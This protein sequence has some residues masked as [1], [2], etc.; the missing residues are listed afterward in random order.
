[1]W[2]MLYFYARFWRDTHSHIQKQ[3]K[4]KTCCWHFCCAYGWM[5]R[6]V[7]CNQTGIIKCQTL[8][9][10]CGKEHVL[11]HQINFSFFCHCKLSLCPIQSIREPLF[12]LSLT[13]TLEQFCCFFADHF[14]LLSHLYSIC[15][16]PDPKLGTLK[17]GGRGELMGMT[18]QNSR[19]KDC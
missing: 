4:L 3:A 10:K 16:H 1:M 19:Q 9:S 12:L 15:V 7:R 8:A 5:Y 14:L 6:S 11:Y 17:R 2:S 18:E 13:E